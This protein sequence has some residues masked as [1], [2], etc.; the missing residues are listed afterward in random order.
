MTEPARQPAPPSERYGERI[1]SHL[2][3]EETDRLTALAQALDPPTF[4]RIEQLPMR[5]D[6]RC[7]EIGAGLGTTA[8]WLAERCPRGR[9]VATDVDTRLF[10]AAEARNG[11]QGM[12]HDVTRDDFPDRSFDLI[13][14]R[15]VL[16]HVRSRDEV[17]PRMVRW[18]APGGWLLVEDLARF[19]LESSPNPLYRKVSLAMCDA[20][21][22]RIGTDFSWARGLSTPL[23]EAG[24]VRVA[25][26]AS[27]ES[28]GP[29]PM[30]RF[31][32]LTAEQLASDM[33]RSFGVTPRDLARF[34]AEV[35]SEDFSDL[36]LATVATRGQ[37]S[38]GTELGTAR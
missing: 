8:S 24:L 38:E 6:W 23:R 26:E 17:L 22:A 30:G 7:L 25:T 36:C 14:L 37:R 21:T 12:E 20:A 9:V 5:D 11:W 29:G 18:L 27:A 33:H 1:F 10:P 35:R 13:H 34:L 15:W 3:P 31:W 19:P 4:R 32:Q 2:T 16:S 28:V